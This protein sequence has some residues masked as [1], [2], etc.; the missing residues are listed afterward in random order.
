MALH[1]LSVLPLAVLLLAAVL[2]CCT[3]VYADDFQYG[4]ATFYDDN[5]Q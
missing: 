4:R 1:V 5:G 2:S 3:L